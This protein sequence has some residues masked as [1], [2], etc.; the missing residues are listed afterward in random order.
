M[1]A[2][3]HLTREKLK[4]RIEK[5]EGSIEL[6]KKRGFPKHL[7]SGVDSLIDK[8]ETEIAIHKLALAQLEE[9]ECCSKKRKKW[10]KPL[11][12]LFDS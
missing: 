7:L 5:I 8:Y 12:S 6:L 9:R 4:R 2:M 3:D 11:G 10:P 1:R